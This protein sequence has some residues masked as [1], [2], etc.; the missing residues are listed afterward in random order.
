MKKVQCGP[1][2]YEITAKSPEKAIKS[3][4]KAEKPV[5]R[6]NFVSK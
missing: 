2:R 1:N 3:R 6:A 4:G 5:R